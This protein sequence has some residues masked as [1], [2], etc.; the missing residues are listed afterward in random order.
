VIQKERMKFKGELK[1]TKLDVT[2]MRK[3][4]QKHEVELLN[5]IK[6]RNKLRK[7]K[8]KLIF[9]NV[10]LKESVDTIKNKV[11]KLEVDHRNATMEKVLFIEFLVD[12][13]CKVEKLEVE[14]GN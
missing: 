14:C 9:E 7:L 1:I 12:Y 2:S 8:I 6:D 3:T 11:E 4:S 5:M 10:S 13:K